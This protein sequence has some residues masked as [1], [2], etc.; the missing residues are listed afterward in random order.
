MRRLLDSN[1]WIDLWKNP[2]GTTAS[3]LASFRFNELVTCSIVKAELL[4]GAKKYGNADRRA[5]M[6]RSALSGLVSL[7]FDDVSAE[8]YAA[9]KHELEL[10]GEIIGPH[11][12]QIAAI[13]VTH[14]LTLVSGN[15]RE[16]SRVPGLAVE[17]WTVGSI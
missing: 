8:H 12:L 16:F 5:K 11:D 10:R 9:I 4:H 7:P 17:D 6:V 1:V 14:G 2:S 15:V 3:K 13:A